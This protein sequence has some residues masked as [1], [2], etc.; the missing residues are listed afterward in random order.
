MTWNITDGKT[1]N[2]TFEI[3]RDRLLRALQIAA[4][5]LLAHTQTQSLIAPLCDDG[6][7]RYLVIGGPLELQRLCGI[8]SRSCPEDC[9]AC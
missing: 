6:D 7:P 8:I 1:M 2:D 4:A 3:E 5:D 9:L